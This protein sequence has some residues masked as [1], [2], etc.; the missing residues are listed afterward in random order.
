MTERI[1]VGGI[2]APCDASKLSDA[3]FMLMLGDL[4][5]EELVDE[6]RLSAM[7]RL[8]R[9]LFANERAAV[10]DA[11]AESN[12]GTVTV[13]AFTAWLVDYLKAVGAKNS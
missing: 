12:G 11:L 3:R 1:E 6:E 5:D 8:T 4:Q 13:D 10:L 7:A 2:D 9:Y